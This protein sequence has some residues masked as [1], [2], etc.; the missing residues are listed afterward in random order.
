MCTPHPTTHRL[1][2]AHGH[3]QL[4]QGS[5][6]LCFNGAHRHAPHIQINVPRGRCC[7][8]D[9]GDVCGRVT[10]REEAE[11]GSWFCRRLAVVVV[12]AGLVMEGRKAWA[13]ET[14]SRTRS[15]RTLARRAVDVGLDI[16]WGLSLWRGGVVSVWSMSVCQRR[17]RSKDFAA[18]SHQ[19]SS[20]GQRGSTSNR[21]VFGLGVACRM[22]WLIDVL[23]VCGLIAWHCLSSTSS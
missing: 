5:K 20:S 17:R 14:K 15:A 10:R 3:L 23:C 12:E 19:S 16:V 1:T 7:R 8:L 21:D 6:V 22:V 18:S 2:H 13:H 9:K 4:G 11:E